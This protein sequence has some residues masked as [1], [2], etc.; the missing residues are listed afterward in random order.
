MNIAILNGYKEITLSTKVYIV[1]AMVFS[2]VMYECESWTIKKAVKAKSFS[3]A[4][5]F[6]TPWTTYT[7]RGSSIH[8][9]FQAQEYWNGL[10]FPSEYQRTDAFKLWG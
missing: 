4:Q 6:V 9:I 2:V 1:K 8:G 10:L 3:C 5:L 7:L